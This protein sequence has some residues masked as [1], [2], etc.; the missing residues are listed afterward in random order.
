MAEKKG[1]VPTG[2]HPEGPSR[3]NQ[4]QAP[5]VPK[6]SQPFSTDSVKPTFHTP[7]GQKEDV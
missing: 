1:L 4:P 5:K 2:Q 7:P 3:V 6:E